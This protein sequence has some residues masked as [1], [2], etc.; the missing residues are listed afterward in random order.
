MNFIS[1]IT[2]WYK[3]NKRDLPW[4]K[5]KD[6]YLIWMSEIILQQTRVNQGLSYYEKF[7]NKYPTVKDL[8]NENED[9]ISWFDEVSPKSNAFDVVAKVIYS[10]TLTLPLTGEGE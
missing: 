2:S 5:T 1:E 3:T 7:S 6:P 9:A 10:I 8:A 4:R